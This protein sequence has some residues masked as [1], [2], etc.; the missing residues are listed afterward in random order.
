M[1]QQ[2]NTTLQW[3]ALA[4]VVLAGAWTLFHLIWNFAGQIA[5]DYWGIALLNPLFSRTAGRFY[6]VL[7]RANYAQR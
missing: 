2:R 6:A 3:G 4:I 5:D 7:L 1:V